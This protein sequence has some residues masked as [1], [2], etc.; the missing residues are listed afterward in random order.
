MTILP[1][2]ISRR[3]RQ[4]QT[5]EAIIF[6][7]RASFARDGYHGAKLE[8]I[9]RTAGFS[10]G[11]V[12]S[13]FANKAELFLA[14]MDMNIEHSFAQGGWDLFKSHPTD[15]TADDDA[16]T[17]IRGFGLATLE[18][19]ALAARDEALHAEVA[20][21]ID[22]LPVI[23]GAVVEGTRKAQAERSEEEVAD[24]L[25]D[26][27]LGALLAALDQ[28][29][30]TLA[31]AGSKA[32][33]PELLRIGMMRLLC[34]AQSSAAEP[35]SLPDDVMLHP[36]IRERLIAAERAWHNQKGR[37]EDYHGHHDS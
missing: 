31:L 18:F 21:R 11:A 28:G 4:R 1:D 10:K 13:N 20:R 14:V 22:M 27:H 32:L 17:V 24:E 2:P 36:A 23:Y 7:A 26:E 12:Y 6:T 3:D 16:T 25:S 8:E 35:S 15:L 9:A 19:V 29:A 34:P 5:R 37:E 30:A 33:N